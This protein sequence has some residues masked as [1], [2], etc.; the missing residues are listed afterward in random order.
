MPIPT[1]E[2]NEFIRLLTDEYDITPDTTVLD[3]GCGAGQYSIAMAK[4]AKR[5]V[6]LDFSEKM[7]ESARI[8]AERNGVTNVEFVKCNWS[9]LSADDPLI[10]DGFDLVI[11]HMTP[12]IGSASDFEKMADTVKEM[13]FYS[14]PVRREREL[15]SKICEALDRNEG[16]QD[17]NNIIYAY[18]LAWHRGLYPKIHYRDG[19]KRKD[20]M[21]AKDLVDNVINELFDKQPLND[22]EK[23][24]VKRIIESST[25]NNGL[26]NAPHHVKIATLYWKVE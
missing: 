17:D 20:G 13:C 15:M 5:V 2:D 22:K 16:V 3:I 19:S 14:L 4:M 18:G 21:L 7:L 6:A 10:Q 24:T 9:E 12:A 25:D 23:H 1:Q 26:I 8:N 11:A